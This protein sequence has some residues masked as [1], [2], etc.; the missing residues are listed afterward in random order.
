MNM[1][2]CLAKHWVLVG[3]KS[4]RD[5]PAIEGSKHNHSETK[6]SVIVI[7]AIGILLIAGVH[8]FRD[9]IRGRDALLDWVIPH[10]PNTQIYTRRDGRG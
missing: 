2:K 6:V 1:V 10:I 3:R 9:A 7:I 5:A 8:V 4:E